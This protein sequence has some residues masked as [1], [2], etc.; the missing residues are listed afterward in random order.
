MEKNG[1]PVPAG[2]QNIDG[3]NREKTPLLE[4]CGDKQEGDS[5]ISSR[6]GDL[7]QENKS[8]APLSSVIS[9]KRVPLVVQ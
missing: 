4:M 5:R 9:Q 6:L 7:S 1:Q 8:A 2:V 3:R